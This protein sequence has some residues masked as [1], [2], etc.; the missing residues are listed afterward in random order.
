MPQHK[1]LAL[2][3]FLL[4][5]H[6]GFAQKQDTTQPPYHFSGTITVT[7][8]GIALVP[9]FSLGKP[10]AIFNLSLGK[11]RLSFE[12]DIRF[13]LEGKPW[14]MLF[15]WR[16][17][18]VKAH[19][20]TLNLGAH[21]AMNFRTVVSPIDGRESLVV[22]RYLAGELVPNYALG[23]HSSIGMY[24]LYSRGIDRDA[25]RNNHFLLLSGTLSNIKL[26]NQ[27]L[28]KITPQVYFLYQDGNQGYYA[29]AMATLSKRRFPLA[30]ST[31]INKTIQSRIIGSKNFVWNLSLVYAFHKKFMKA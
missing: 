31:I 21:P 5:A 29:A 28:F 20:F 8:N 15:W 17:K 10:A 1:T 4:I 30:I 12:P 25:T 26:G 6:G 23:K 24:Y 16:Y 7:N 18:L 19:K 9:T 11:E 14:S 27:L 13:S 2:L 22:R 3:V